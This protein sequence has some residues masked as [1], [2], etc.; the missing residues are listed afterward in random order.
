MPG[1]TRG[2]T[3]SPRPIAGAPRRASSHAL[4]NSAGFG[5]DVGMTAAPNTS[6]GFLDNASQSSLLAEHPRAMNQRLLSQNMT[7]ALQ[8][9][10]LKKEIMA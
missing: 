8:M 7:L 1:I 9:V 4:A 3:T 2:R 10:D 6:S 5:S